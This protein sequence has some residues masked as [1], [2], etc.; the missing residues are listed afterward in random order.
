MYMKSNTYTQEK[1]QNIQKIENAAILPHKLTEK[2]VHILLM[3]SPRIH[4]FVFQLFLCL[5]SFPFFMSLIVVC[6][7][8]LFSFSF[9]NNL[10]LLVYVVMCKMFV[11]TFELYNIAFFYLYHTHSLLYILLKYR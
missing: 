11:V 7:F 6:F 1:E 9:S 5:F 8:F 4:S 10:R 3:C 2:N